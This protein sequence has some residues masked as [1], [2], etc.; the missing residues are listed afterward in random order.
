MPAGVLVTVPLPDPVFATDSECVTGGIR[1]KFA[2]TA[3]V[4]LIVTV[5]EVA[6][7]EQ[8]PVQ[9]VKVDPGAGVAVSVTGV[10]SV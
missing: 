10:P 8:S 2:V 5:H 4:L 3:V 9:P 1:S 7:P 6:V